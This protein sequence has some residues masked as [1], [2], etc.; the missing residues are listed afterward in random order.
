MKIENLDDLDI[1][2][3]SHDELNQLVSR[4]LTH[5]GHDGAWKAL[6]SITDSMAYIGRIETDSRIMVFASRFCPD[7][8][9]AIEVQS[10]VPMPGSFDKLRSVGIPLDAGINLRMGKSVPVMCK[11]SRIGPNGFTELLVDELNRQRKS[12]GEDGDSMEIRFV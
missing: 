11:S 10:F 8:P 1:T 12:E 5:V 7:T 2:Q 4:V 6:D 3:Y 9:N